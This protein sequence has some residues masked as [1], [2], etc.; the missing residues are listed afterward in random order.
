VRPADLLAEA[1]R[2]LGPGEPDDHRLAAVAGWLRHQNLDGLPDLAAAAREQRRLRLAERSGGPLLALAAFPA[3]EPTDIHGHGSWAAGVVVSGRGRH[4]RWVPGDDGTARLAEIRELAAGDAFWLPGPPDG[5][6]RQIAVGGDTLELILLGRDRRRSPRARYR[7]RT[8]T[9]DRI[10]GCLADGDREELVRLYRPDAICDVNVPEWRFQLQGPDAIGEA[11]R[12]E[13]DVPGRRCTFLRA[14]RTEDGLLVETEMRFPRDG[15]EWLWRDLHRFR[16][17]GPRIAE[18]VISCT[19]HWSPETI[20]RQA[21][22]SP[23]VRP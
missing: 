16:L 17:D 9:G 20:A 23:M 18:H 5:A 19:G 1:E 12:E 3:G 2:R 7:P 13:L 4:E 10:A 22:E 15:R 14:T 8:T 21:A 6:H 11:L